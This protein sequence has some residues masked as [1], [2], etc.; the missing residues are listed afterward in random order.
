MHFVSPD[1]TNNLHHSPLKPLFKWESFN[2]IQ[3]PIPVVGQTQVQDINIYLPKWMVEI[4]FSPITSQATSKDVFDLTG[5]T[6]FN[7]IQTNNCCWRRN[8]SYRKKWISLNRFCGGRSKV[9]QLQKIVVSFT[10]SRS[11]CFRCAI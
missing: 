10:R 1:I 5:A 8:E 7:G 3:C 4:Q 6:S 9:Y 11:N 2:D